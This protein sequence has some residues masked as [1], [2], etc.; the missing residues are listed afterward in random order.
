LVQAVI[1]L[2]TNTF[3][4]LVAEWQKGKDAIQIHE[5]K[6]YAVALGLGAMDTGMIQAEAKIRAFEALTFFSE[7]LQQ[8]PN[9]EQVTA[10]GTSVIRNAKNGQQFLNEI[11]EKFGF[12]CQ[13]ISG[14]READLIFWGVYESM[15]QPWQERSIIM[16][17]GGGSTEFIVFEGRKILFKQS[18]EIGGLKLLSM[19]NENGAFSL[20]R[21]SDLEKYVIDQISQVKAAIQRYQPKHLIGAAGAFE[22]LFDLEMASTKKIPTDL[23]AFSKPLSIEI[24]FKHKRLLEELSLKE[25]EMYPGMKPFRAGILPMAM[26]EI[27]LLLREMQ[28]KKLWFS[29]FSLKE[30]YFFETVRKSYTSS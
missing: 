30:G 4:L 14:E 8:Y 17:I 12:T 20:N 26:I 29:D 6:T 24:F 10:I 16:D 7:I 27:E 15:P 18:V 9:I 5:N 22:T 13:M 2:G 11:T 23:N 21:K 1:D 3:Q 19:F 28:E 25:R